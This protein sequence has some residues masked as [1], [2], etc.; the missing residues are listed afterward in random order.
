MAPAWSAPLSDPTPGT[1]PAAT[2]S[3]AR[4][5]M[6]TF[7]YEI[8]NALDNFV[9]LSIG[10]G[11]LGGGV[12]LTAFNTLQSWTVYTTNDYLWEKYSPPKRFTGAEDGF[13]ANQ[14]F[15]RTTFK[16]M[17]GKPVVASI[18]ITAL[19]VYT[20]SVATALGFGLAA[21]AGASMI[22]FVN[23]MAW[24]YFSDRSA[25]DTVGP[26]ATPARAN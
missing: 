6:R 26:A 25:P 13:D 12:L 19:Y 15:W 9:I 21:T 3:F 2:A 4:S 24:D 1:A 20:G 14:S 23:N 18:K 8:G 22:F 17:T 16:Y 11:D 10:S 7:T 5:G